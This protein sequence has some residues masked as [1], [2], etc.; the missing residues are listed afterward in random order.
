MLTKSALS[1]LKR[2]TLSPKN[3]G[4]AD[5]E[6]YLCLATI[7]DSDNVSCLVI[8]VNSN[9]RRLTYEGEIS[10]QIELGCCSRMNIVVHNNQHVFGYNGLYKFYFF[11]NPLCRYVRIRYRAIK[12]TYLSFKA[13]FVK[14]N[15]S[16]DRVRNEV[17]RYQDECRRKSILCQCVSADALAK[18]TH[19]WLFEITPKHAKCKELTSAYQVALGSLANKGELSGGSGHGLDFLPY[20]IFDSLRY[21]AQENKRTVV[22]HR[23][24]II[25][26]I[27]LALLQLIFQYIF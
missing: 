26:S 22:M 23:Q 8:D 18:F 2:Y 10:I 16:I 21:V 20:D 15:V 13:Y 14:C 24:I 17:I 11:D 25:V 9:D 6:E 27:L 3:P 12:Q 19:R 7:K 4:Y 5:S 1:K